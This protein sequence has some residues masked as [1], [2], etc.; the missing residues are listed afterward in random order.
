MINEIANCPDLQ[1]SAGKSCNHRSRKSSFS[2]ARRLKTWLRSTMTQERFQRAAR[3]ER[4][5]LEV[6]ETREL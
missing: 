2:A 3:R 4:T 5:I 6:N 1:T